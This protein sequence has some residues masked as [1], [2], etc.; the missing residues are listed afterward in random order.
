MM[1]RSRTQRVL[2]EFVFL[3]LPLNFTVSLIYLE[4]FQQNLLFFKLGFA[5][6]NGHLSHSNVRFSFY[7]TAQK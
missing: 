7:L 5:L 3:I 1:L 6:I 2:R 4:S